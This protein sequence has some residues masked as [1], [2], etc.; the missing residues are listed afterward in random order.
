MNQQNIKKVYEVVY[1]LLRIAGF[2]G[3]GEFPAK[4]EKAGL[5]LLDSAIAGNEAE[6]AK[7][8]VFI[9]YLMRIGSDVGIINPA[10]AQV[11]IRESKSINPAI[12]GFSPING[13][14]EV[15]IS[16]IFSKNPTL[17][18]S[19]AMVRH[20]GEKRTSEKVVEERTQINAVGVTAQN[21]EE[22]SKKTAEETDS[23]ND[24]G[25]VEN[26]G[27]KTDIDGPSEQKRATHDEQQ[28]HSIIMRQGAIV[29]RIRQIGNCRIKD[30]QGL[31]PEISER[32]LRY[33]IQRLVEEG[34]VERMGGGGPATYYRLP[35]GT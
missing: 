3:K 15:K 25:D 17:G 19:R 27:R 12:A 32:T 1:A 2:I 5:N 10:N 7:A 16:D 11:I 24:S 28:D 30:I 31:L 8:L 29:E 23:I 33:D 20:G 35:P 26:N 22:I 6:A 34:V 4:L 9:E 14:Q 13:P 21:A 18:K